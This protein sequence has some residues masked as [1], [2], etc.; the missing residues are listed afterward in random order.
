MFGHLASCA[1]NLKNYLFKMTWRLFSSAPLTFTSGSQFIQRRCSEKPFVE[2]HVS[3]NIGP[4]VWKQR[5]LESSCGIQPWFLSQIMAVENPFVHHSRKL[6]L[7]A[8]SGIICAR[9]M[10]TFWNGTFF[11]NSRWYYTTSSEQDTGNE[12]RNLARND[13]YRH[14]SADLAVSAR[15]EWLS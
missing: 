15:L 2:A 13:E 10:P 1:I 12:T 5:W 11:S 9:L 3:D 8:T 7:F 14:C 4:R 6:F